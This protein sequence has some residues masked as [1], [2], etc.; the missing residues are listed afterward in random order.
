MNKVPLI[1]PPKVRV[2]VALD[3]VQLIMLWMIWGGGITLG[4]MAFIFELIFRYKSKSEK[5]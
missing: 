1:P 4:K 2:G 5:K 3:P